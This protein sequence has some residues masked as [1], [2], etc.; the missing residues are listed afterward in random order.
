MTHTLTKSLLPPVE[1]MPY[2]PDV[3]RLSEML[4]STTRT[5]DKQ[6]FRVAISY[7][8][9]VMAS[10]MRAVIKTPDK[11]VSLIN[12]YAIGLGTSGVGK[13]TT[14]NLME[15]YVIKNF[16]DNFLNT[17]LEVMAES[18]F[19]NIALRRAS[20][21]GSDPEAEMEKVKR[22]WES[23]GDLLF[24]FNSGTVS[25][26][27]QIRHKLK[28][29]KCGSF[30]LYVDE[31]GDNMGTIKE[32]KPTFLEL[33]DTG[34]T[35]QKLVKN[36]NENLRIEDM[37]GVTPA[38]MLLFGAPERLFDG[39]KV[40]ADFIADLET[41][42]ARRSFFAYVQGQ[43]R[44]ITTDIEALYATIVENCNYD[45]VS[46]LNDKYA[47]LAD[48][49]KV[50][51]VFEL[52]P[53][54]YKILLQ[55]HVDCELEAEKLPAHETVLKT[56]MVN[57]YSKAL[58]LAGA[59]AFV[60]ESPDIEEKHL[61]YAIKLAE[62]S[63]NAF[64]NIAKRDKS[65]VRLARYLAGIPENAAVTHADLIEDLH[66]YPQAQARRSEMVTMA[67]AHGYRNNIIIKK[68]YEHGIEFLY[69]ETLEETN[70]DEMYLSYSTDIT[71]NYQFE[72]APWDKLHKLTQQPNLH[73]ITHATDNGHRTQEHM[74]P[75]FNLIVFDVD[76]TAKVEQVQTLLQE[77]T[78][79][80][81]TTKRHDPNGDHRFRILL[82]CNYI[83][84]LNDTDFSTFMK[85]VAE[86]L[87]FEVDTKTFQR[88]R[89]W[90]T[91]NGQHHYNE[92]KLFDVVPFIP[93]TDKDEKRQ[94]NF[95]EY[96][97]LEALERWVLN[98]TGAGN[99]NDQL[100]KYAFL[101]IDLGNSYEQIR[102]KVT[103]LNDKLP[104]KL[105]E[106]EI[107]STIMVSVS[108]KLQAKP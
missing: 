92:G 36:T 18:N 29:A 22:D 10:M 50:G 33:F 89:K 16:Q 51:Q 87:P 38:N 84:K 47:N 80:L 54:I 68:F 17:T 14:T 39:G 49:N 76:G 82:P 66:F 101:L 95:S 2:H 88:S 1:E 83:L 19:H 23:S 41:G 69:G 42:L 107:S 3:E 81:Y 65:H 6:F 28:M 63:G 48:A 13:G 43:N 94:R 24:S 85:S 55:Y 15:E 52:S 60:D 103:E 20:R 61:H 73:W 56:E 8:M 98:N 44:T 31:I 79:M 108:K 78:Y 46:D 32:L 26:L 4:S 100:I 30:C 75:G 99:R 70:L 35:K 7:Y 57:R 102:A 11:R 72:K 53:D 45:Y 25:A 21:K 37:P 58:K 97:S 27:N 34:N 106:N 40:E 90:L 104:D 93:R 86:W 5:K 96:G 64:Y 91:N 12:M 105:S 59:Y 9:A 71:Y 77:Y 67:T 74:V 62:E